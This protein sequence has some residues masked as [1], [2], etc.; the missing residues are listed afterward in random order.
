MIAMDTPSNFTKGTPRG[1]G[2]R[3]GC[4]F[5]NG[6]VYSKCIPVVL[7]IKILDDPHIRIGALVDLDELF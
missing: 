3:L 2:W 5:I 4:Y 7:C 6:Y 1:V